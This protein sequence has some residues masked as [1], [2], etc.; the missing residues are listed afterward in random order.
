MSG[1]SSVTPNGYQAVANYPG[2]MG[3]GGMGTGFGIDALLILL[4]LGG[5]NGGLGGWGNRAGGPAAT[6]VTTDVIMQPA[7]QSL[8]QQISGLASQFSASQL[9]EAVSNVSDQVQMSGNQVVQNQ[10]QIRTDLQNGNFQTLTSLN[11]LNRDITAQNTQLLINDNQ[12]TQLVNGNIV[13]GF[14]QQNLATLTGFNG[15]KDA[16]CAMSREMAECCCETQKSIQ[17]SIISAKDNT[18][19]ILNQMST[20]KYAELLEKY[21]AVQAANSNL[22]QTNILKD[23]N[24]AQTETILRHLV[25]FFGASNGNSSRPS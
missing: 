2:G 25:P 18:Q 5:G 17:A 7:F 8:Q 3:L 9:T 4:L 14:N 19:M 10:G 24:A 13:N 16:I 12:Q 23:N 21:N 20:D 6:A 22:I 15:V 1:Y 11:G